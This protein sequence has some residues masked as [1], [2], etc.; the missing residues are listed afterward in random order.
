M[1]GGGVG[2]WAYGNLTYRLL[3]GILR[4][5][6]EQDANKRGANTVNWEATLVVFFLLAAMFLYVWF[7]WWF[8]HNMLLYL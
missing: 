4:H 7:C 2:E 3:Y 8:I 5:N 1:V 6:K